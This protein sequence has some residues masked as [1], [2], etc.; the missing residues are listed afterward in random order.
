MEM[1]KMTRKSKKIGISGEEPKEYRDFL[2]NLSFESDEDFNLE[3]DGNGGLGISIVRL[4]EGG[5][6]E[7]LAQQMKEA[8]LDWRKERQCIICGKSFF[9]K[10]SKQLCCSE[11]C[12]YKKKYRNREWHGTVEIILCEWCGKKC[13]STGSWSPDSK[14]HFCSLQCLGK[15]HAYQLKQE[16]RCGYQVTGSRLGKRSWELRWER[17]GT[18]RLTEEE[19]RQRQV[20]GMRRWRAKNPDKL[21]A[22]QERAKERKKKERELRERARN[23]DYS[24]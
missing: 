14:H 15:W 21:K 17:T 22:Q 13:L 4:P 19:K 3:A 24:D 5:E 8:S 9:P 20:E 2:K 6:K 11:K 16:G 23:V 7:R 10:T 12:W 18:H 1:I